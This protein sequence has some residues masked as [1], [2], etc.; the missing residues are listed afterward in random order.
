MSNDDHPFDS[1]DSLLTR[2][3]DR[4]RFLNRTLGAGASLAGG[5]GLLG[6]FGNAPAWANA[7]ADPNDPV[8][9]PLIEGAK[10]EGTV[11]VLGVLLQKAEGRRGFADAMKEYYGLPS[12]FNVN[13][14]VKPVGPTQKQVEDELVANKVSIDVVMLNTVG[15]AHSLAQRG[16]LMSFDAPEYKNFEH[17]KEHPL[18]VNRP[19]YVCDPGYLVMIS[20]NSQVIKDETF[21]SW[22]DLLKPEY[23]GKI[24]CHSARITPSF[25]VS[26]YAMKNEP[27]IGPDFF[28]RLAAQETVTP[29]I[30]EQAADRVLTGEWPIA[31]SAGPRVYSYWEQGAK[32]VKTSFP[33]EGTVSLPSFWLGLDAAPHPN[34][35][36]L[37]LNFARTQIAGQLL[38]EREARMSSRTDVTSPN[39]DFIPL[40]QD[41]KWL[42]VDQLKL[43]PPVMRQL[44]DEWREMFGT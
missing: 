44:G 33:K 43:T 5:S 32:H 21:G 35:A 31:M 24:S 3:L 28:K 19:F 40:V 4:R 23:K 39:R 20:W 34:A 13:W 2:A 36:K 38:M 8:L 14:V 12:S 41:K 6:A 16:K 1:D 9:G 27:T 22:F 7:K 30:S 26:Y 42:Y 29:Q 17:M 25:A 18:F 10:R 37:A 11:T 15:F